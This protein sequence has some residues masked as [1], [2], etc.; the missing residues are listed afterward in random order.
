MFV[1]I[2]GGGLDARCWEPLVPLLDGEVVAVD[3]PG[4]GRR[5]AGLATVTLADFVAAVVD[6]LVMNDLED[7]TLVGHSMAGITM[8][9]VAAVVPERL[10]QLVFVACAV[11]AK[12]E[13]VADVLGSFSPTAAKIAAQLGPAVVDEEGRLNDDLARAMFCNDMNGEQVAYTLARMVSEAAGVVD[14]PT[15]PRAAPSGMPRAYV[16]LLRDQS[17]TVASQDRA[18]ENLGGAD[19][20]DLDAGHMAMIS[21]PNQLAEILNSLRRSV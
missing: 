13:S 9:L 4:R 21:A 7:V 6:D 16:R 14:E 3:L 15:D 18:I 11:P 10:R 12:G 19:V 17:L 1:L 8:P 20:V 5:P 2:H